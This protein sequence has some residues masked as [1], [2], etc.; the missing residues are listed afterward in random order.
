MAASSALEL[1]YAKGVQPLT[2][3]AAKK[4]PYLEVPL[5]RIRVHARHTCGPLYFG[6]YLQSQKVGWGQTDCALEQ[7]NGRE[8]LR[9]EMEIRAR[10]QRFGGSADMRQRWEVIWDARGRGLLLRYRHVSRVGKK[11]RVVSLKRGS[12]GW[13]ATESHPGAD[14]PRKPT[15][16]EIES[17]RTR[18]T[19]GWRA[20][21]TQ[22]AAGSL[23]VGSRY[24]YRVFDDS[25][26]TDADRALQV[27]ATGTR[28]LRGV[29]VPLYE[30]EHL[31]LPA[32]TRREILRDDRG[33]LL[34]APTPGGLRLRRE[35]KATAR[36][37]DPP[38]VDYGLGLVIPA[39]IEE[40]DTPDRVRRMQVQLRGPLPKNLADHPRHTVR[41]GGRDVAELTVTRESLRGLPAVR[42][43]ITE[44]KLRPYLRQEPG[45]EVEHPRIQA[46]AR[47]ALQGAR[48]P[49][50]AARRVALY[51][52]T[53]LIKRLS[54]SQDSA[55]A[56]AT[57]RVGD[58][59]EHA[60]LM[61]ALCRAVGLPAREVAGL[62]WIPEIQGFVYHAWVEVYVGGG[63]WISAD[64]T[65]NELP[66][67][68]TRIVMGGPA[69]AGWLGLRGVLEATVGNVEQE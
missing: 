60:R 21:V 42:L 61:V 9:E 68:A 5:A 50:E 20:Y 32:G 62:A 6:V 12:Q 28:R 29:T 43:P 45:L 18:L 27:L 10:V 16:R 55:L 36:R 13:L 64:P 48:R 7:R 14:P 31:G 25:S 33:R 2:V 23:A 59:T 22:L 44:A 47:R 15:T 52:H 1:P 30:L 40:I 39:E 3:A 69:D 53:L 63:R 34:D 49:L 46:L 38:P 24:R 37:V 11:R 51:L 66:V 35:E 56:V 41:P 58:C 26:L 17:L 54:T 65:L 4:L 19:N 8:V 57:S 67:N